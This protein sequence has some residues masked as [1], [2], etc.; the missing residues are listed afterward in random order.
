MGRGSGW[1]ACNPGAL[2]LCR[3]HETRSSSSRIGEAGRGAVMGGET[4]RPQQPTSSPF[5]ECRKQRARSVVGLVLCVCVCVCVR[6]LGEVKGSVPLVVSMLSV[7]GSPCIFHQ[8]MDPS[9]GP[10]HSAAD[11]TLILSLILSVCLSVSLSVCVSLSLCICL[12]AC[13]T[14]SVFLSVC[15]FLCV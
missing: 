15:L 14:L 2:N 7:S 6:R 10:S 12:S 5:G 4:C 8:R 13:P 3:A 9:Y 1:R 11:K